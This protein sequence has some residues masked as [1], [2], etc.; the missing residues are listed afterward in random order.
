MAHAITPDDE[1]KRVVHGDETVGRVVKVDHGTA[2]V[3]PDPGITEMITSKLG[4][5]DRNED[6][7]PLQ[8]E[9]IREITDDEIRLDQSMGPGGT[10]STSGGMTDTGSTGGVRDT[11]TH[12]DRP[13]DPADSRDDRSSDD[14]L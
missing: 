1:G 14:I 4:W 6:T 2:Y 12:D 10:S 11:G 8:E 13:G 9:S 7:Y 3:D 5:G